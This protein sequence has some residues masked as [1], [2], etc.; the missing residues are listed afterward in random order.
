MATDISNTDDIIDSRDVI[1]RIEELESEL[2][3]LMDAV[4]EAREALTALDDIN[5]AGELEEAEDALKDAE[6]DLAD[7]DAKHHDERRESRRAPNGHSLL[8]SRIRG[9]H[10]F[11]VTG[12]SV[13]R[14]R[15]LSALRRR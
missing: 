1:A 10:G 8:G 15:D 13:T 4:D 2:E 9:G 11:R 12:L 14:L 7:W 5:T 6:S 3:T